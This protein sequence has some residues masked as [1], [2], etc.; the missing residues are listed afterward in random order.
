MIYQKEQMSHFVLFYNIN[1]FDGFLTVLTRL[2]GGD[3]GP[4]RVQ[5]VKTDTLGSLP[6]LHRDDGMLLY[7][8]PAGSIDRKCQYEIVLNR[9]TADNLNSAFR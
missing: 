6:I 4:N 2:L 1:I 9:T 3:A 5:E 8:P 7:G